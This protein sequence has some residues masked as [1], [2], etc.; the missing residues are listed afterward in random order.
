M[1]SPLPA[2]AGGLAA[3]RSFMPRLTTI[4]FCFDPS[5]RHYRLLFLL[6]ALLALGREGAFLAGLRFFGILAPDRRAWARA[7]AT[8]CF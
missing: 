8:A 3:G 2:S 5:M 1:S 6:V 4:G 7:A